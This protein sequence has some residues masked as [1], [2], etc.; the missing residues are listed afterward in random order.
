VI[1][2][3][4]FRKAATAEGLDFAPMGTAEQYAEAVGH[5][6]AWDG[7]RGS[8]VLAPFALSAIRD[9][10]KAIERV[11]TPGNSIVVG[12]RYSFAALLAKEK[13]ALPTITLL[14]NLPSLRSIYSPPCV[15]PV[16]FLH[17]LGPAAARLVFRVIDHKYSRLFRIP[18]NQVRG[19]LGLPPIQ[20]LH[21][22]WLSA[23]LLIA[24]WPEWLHAPQPDWPRQAVCTGF[25]DYD[26][27]ST[28][29]NEKRESGT[30]SQAQPS[31]VF[32]AGTGMTH[33]QKFF[34]AAVQV[35]LAMK[36]SGV[37]LTQYREQIPNDLPS[38]V[39][40]VTYAPFSELLPGALALV[41]AG[42]IGTSA[43]AL[44]SGIPQLIIPMA[45]DQ[46]ENAVRFT[47]L[48]VARSL[49]RNRLSAS[50]MIKLLQELLESRAVAE[51]CGYWAARMQQTSALPRI[52]SLIENFGRHHQPAVEVCE[53]QNE[54]FC[55]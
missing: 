44:K 22:W 47:N 17:H 55:C 33:A 42:G 18:I 27:A 41:H 43:R 34:T 37:L 26:G 38:C 12:S 48:G 5:P 6:S 21:Q 24:S 19:E 40:H 23:D 32:T 35:C 50:T 16:P 2:N 51:R 45:H 7:S 20:N 30:W 54:S 3:E 10:F 13:L 49:S 11:Y 36:R 46:F 4:H 39:Q 1:A 53:P 52:C 14:L 28:V 9:G 15:A 29:A 8:Q 31:I 25:I